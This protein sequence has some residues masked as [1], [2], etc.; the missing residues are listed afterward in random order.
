MSRLTRHAIVFATFAVI[1]ATLAPRAMAGSAKLL[2]SLREM[3]ADVVL[4]D[5]SGVGQSDN[6]AFH[7]FGAFD[8]TVSVAADI[9][10]DSPSSGDEGAARIHQDSTASNAG[11]SLTGDYDFRFGADVGPAPEGRRLGNVASQLFAVWEVSGGNVLMDMNMTASTTPAPGRLRFQLQEAVTSDVL[12][13]RNGDGATLHEVLTP[14]RY[15]V[16]WE[17]G[18][19]TDA[20]GTIEDGTHAFDVKFT[21]AGPGTPVPLPPA[22]WSAI[23]AALI[24]G[25]GFAWRRLASRRDAGGFGLSAAAN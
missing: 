14:G 15:R 11:V 25:A 23:A 12:I 21:D 4:T 5:P 13:E 3:R 2:V 7:E 1:L 6:I 8:H 16:A 10:P 22:A 18:Q 19:T 9:T 17:F 20:A 24:P